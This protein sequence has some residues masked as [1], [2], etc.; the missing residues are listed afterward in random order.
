M[1]AQNTAKLVEINMGMV[2]YN[3]ATP[4]SLD[5]QKTNDGKQSVKN[6]CFWNMNLPLQKHYFSTELF[7]IEWSVIGGWQFVKQLRDIFQYGLKQTYK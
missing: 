2:G 3:G 7:K 6:V 4:S 5:S 1:R